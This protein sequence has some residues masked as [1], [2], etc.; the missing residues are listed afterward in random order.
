MH[1]ECIPNGDGGQGPIRV[2]ANAGVFHEKD[3]KEI[4][5]QV[6]NTGTK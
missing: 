6:S 2:D 4:A 3:R 1:Y 5:I